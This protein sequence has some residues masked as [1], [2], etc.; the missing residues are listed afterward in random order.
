MRGPTTIYRQ[1]RAFDRGNAG[2]LVA[3]RERNLMAAA[4]P[5]PRGVASNCVSGGTK[6]ANLRS[7]VRERTAAAGLCPRSADWP[8]GMNCFFLSRRT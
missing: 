4:L 5:Y 1:C 3:L 6:R 8:S 2:N 7:R